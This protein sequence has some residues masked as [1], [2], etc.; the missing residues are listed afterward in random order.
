MLAAGMRAREQQ[1]LAQAVEQ[2]HARFDLD[3]ARLPVD[4]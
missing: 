4:R 3:E 2:A 1:V